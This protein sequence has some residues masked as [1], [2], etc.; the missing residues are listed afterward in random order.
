MGPAAPHIK[1]LSDIYRDL[2]LTFIKMFKV[3]FQDGTVVLPD[4][5]KIKVKKWMGNDKKL[6]QEIYSQVSIGPV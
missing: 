1:L 3:K 6:F 2:Y 4:L 5:F